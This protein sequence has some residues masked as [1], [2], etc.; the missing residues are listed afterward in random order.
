MKTLTLDTETDIYNKGNPFDNRNKLVCASWKVN[1]EQ[2]GAEQWPGIKGFIQDAINACDLLVMFNGKFDYHWLFNNGVSLAGKRIWDCQVAHYILMKQKAIFPSLN[3][4]ALHYGLPVKL[5]VVK[6][7]YWEKDI[8]TSDIPWPILQEY[9]VYDAELT[10]QVFLRQWAEATPAQRALILLDG[11]DC[12]VLREMEANGILFDEEICEERAIQIDDQIREIE[13]K[14]QSTYPNVPIN[15]ASNDD[16]SAFLYG[17]T[18]EETIKVHEGF[19]KT[20]EKKGQPKLVNQ[21]ITHNLPQ[22][23]KPI[24]GSELKKAGYYATNE[25]TLRSLKGNTKIVDLILELA[26]LAKING[27]YYKGL[28]KMNKEMN[29]PKGILHSNFNTTQ[30]VTGRLS[31]S[32]P[33][34]QNFSGD[35]LD[36]FTSAYNE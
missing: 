27:T 9:A 12:H 14:L 30:T 33:N 35:I 32:K 15:F 2:A 6:T 34:Q 17:G 3:D 16:M 19:Y 5:D 4:V 24:K 10:H 8:T 28:P 1:N 11:Q 23:Y 22:L 26:K 7:E 25:P 36:I 18:I 31:S 21:T 20:G 29:W 13:A